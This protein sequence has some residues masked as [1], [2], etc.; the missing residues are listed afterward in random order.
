MDTHTITNARSSGKMLTFAGDI[1]YRTVN[2]FIDLIQQ[3]PNDTDPGQLQITISTGGGDVDAALL[4]HDFLRLLPRRIRMF[5]SG[6]VNSAGI[7]PFLA[8][9]LRVA[10]QTARFHFHPCSI[11][12]NGNFTATDL[13]ERYRDLEVNRGRCS[14]IVT[15][16]TSLD[17]ATHDRL[18]CERRILSIEDAIR[19]GIIHGTVYYPQKEDPILSQCAQDPHAAQPAESK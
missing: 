11:D 2:E 12:L 14:A 16:R 3:I 13:D 18:C 6:P 15:T 8:G 10:Y 5:A 17:A 1:N 19:F 7:Y 9:D 4:L